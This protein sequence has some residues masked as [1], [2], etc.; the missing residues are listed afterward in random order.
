MA[1]DVVGDQAGA[2]TISWSSATF[3]RQ[4]RFAAWHELLCQQLHRCAAR[5][6]SP[7]EFS[8]EA[9]FID[10][11]D[12]KL[13]QGRV[14]SHEVRT[15]RRS[16]ALDD[17]EIFSA[18]FP[19]GGRVVIEQERRQTSVERG[20]FTFWDNT[21]PG[22]LSFDEGTSVLVVQ[23]P[24][25]WAETLIAG[26]GRR[27]QQLARRFEYVGAS[28]LVADFVHGLARLSE[29][30]PD[31][32]RLL[33]GNV[34]GLMGS[35]LAL[36]GGLQPDGAHI[37]TL[38]KVQVIRYLLSQLADPTLD[39]DKVAKAF[40]VS[41]RTLYRLF[42]EAPDQTVSEGGESLHATLRRLRVN[43]AARMLRAEPRVPLHVVARACGFGAEVTLH[44]SFLRL[45]GRTPGQ[46]RAAFGPGRGRCCYPDGRDARGP[47]AV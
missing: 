38:G 31:Q 36:A 10:Y 42:S 4:E 19:L 11:P 47:A 25:A 14:A 39:A 17:R 22:S 5:A 1:G 43:R 37:Q 35:V 15:T 18:A 6:Q 3:E 13:V 34:P 8:A 44:R 29:H 9:S 24:L 28:A 32:A 46:Y 33:S 40:N 27:D 2:P 7:D 21:R 12:F 26:R 23:T 45:H 20:E 41:R 30:D 16:I